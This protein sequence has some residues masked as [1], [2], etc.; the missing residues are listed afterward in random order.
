MKAKILLLALSLTLVAAACNKSAQTTNSSDQ[1]PL[2][3]QTQSGDSGSTPSVVAS[4]VQIS[5]TS[6]GF[7]PANVTVA[8]GTTVV[9]VNND[10]TKHW[11]ASGPH[12]THT[13][14]PGFDSKPG[15]APGQSYEFT[16]DKVGTWAF[17]D[18]LNP[19]VSGSVTVQ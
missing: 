4:K 6:A 7:V 12:P 9:F 3:T 15:L 19:S 1:L 11:P 10:T 5:I 13:A 17:H 16:F 2:A 8:P 18:H 14:L